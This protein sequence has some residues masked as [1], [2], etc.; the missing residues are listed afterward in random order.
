MFETRVVL[1]HN[2]TLSQSMSARG[3]TTLGK[4][5]TRPPPSDALLL[6]FSKSDG[7]ASIRPSPTGPTRDATGRW[8]YFRPVPLDEKTS[9]EWRRKIGSKVAEMM[10]IP[11]Q[12][13]IRYLRTHL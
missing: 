12:S 2:D 10:S 5:E 1:P 13:F 4:E 7:D 6:H 8:N 11:S 9:T 3:V